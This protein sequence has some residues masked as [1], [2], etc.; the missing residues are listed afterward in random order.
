MFGEYDHME[1]VSGNIMM[2]QT[3]PIG[4][5]SVDI[6]FDEER[7]IDALASIEEEEEVVSEL[8]PK[9]SEYCKEENFEF[10]I[11]LDDL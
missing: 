9:R 4:T 3:V 2:G 7:Y 1:G 5:G 6:L 11:S 8:P 10:S